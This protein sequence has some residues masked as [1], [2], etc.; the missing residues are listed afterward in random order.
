MSIANCDEHTK[1]L[2]VEAGGQ[3]IRAAVTQGIVENIIAADPSSNVMH[4][5]EQTTGAEIIGQVLVCL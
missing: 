3:G 2:Q 5:L 1:L 4:A